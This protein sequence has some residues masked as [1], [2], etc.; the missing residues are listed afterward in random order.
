MYLALLP[1]TPSLTSSFMYSLCLRGLDF[2]KV[3]LLPINYS[4][5]LCFKQRYILVR[6]CVWHVCV[7]VWYVCVC[8]WYVCVCVWYVCECRC[9]RACVCVGVFDIINLPAVSCVWTASGC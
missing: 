5:Y 1:L 2:D 9:V 8:V 4:P 3:D 7:C 6:V